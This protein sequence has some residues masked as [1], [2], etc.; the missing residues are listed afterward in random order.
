MK[1]GDLVKWTGIGGNIG[2]VIAHAPAAGKNE[3]LVAWFHS[4]GAPQGWYANF[5][6]ELI[7]ESR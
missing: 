3:N 4:S 1:V 2:I 5:M 6:L 7:S